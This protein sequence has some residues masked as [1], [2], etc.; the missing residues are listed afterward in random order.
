MIEVSNVNWLPGHGFIRQALDS[1]CGPGQLSP[2]LA[3]WG[4]SHVL[5][6]VRV[7]LPQIVEHVLHD[8]QMDHP[9]STEY[10]IYLIYSQTPQP[11]WT[12]RKYDMHI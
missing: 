8:P 5:V 3:G 10:N 12:A 6:R 11:P 2:L 9:P 4:L 1:C 7:P